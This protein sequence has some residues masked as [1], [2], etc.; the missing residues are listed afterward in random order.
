PR[1]DAGLLQEVLQRQAVDDRA[2]HAH[3]VRARPVDAAL[4]QERA[5]EHVAA[6]D[7]DTDLHP[8]ADDVADLPCDVGHD[9]GIDAELGTARLTRAGERLTGELEQDAVPLPRRVGHRTASSGWFFSLARDRDRGDLLRNRL[10]T[11]RSA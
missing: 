1:L 3:V 7:D 5:A 9:P 4:R 11:G 10:R 8:A 2:E 6:A